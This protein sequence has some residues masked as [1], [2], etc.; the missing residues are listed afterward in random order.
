MPKKKKEIK[1]PIKEIQPAKPIKIEMKTMTMTMEDVARICVNINKEYCLALNDKSK[2][3]WNHLDE[4]KKRE[5]KKAINEHLIKNIDPESS[6]NLWMSEKT[7]QGWV[8]GVEINE[9]ERTH[10]CIVHWSELPKEQKA[11]D[12]L[13]CTI[14][15]ELKR[16]L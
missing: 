3:D 7:K 6:H 2:K 10:P 14:I 9:G 12:Y 4:E 15:N 11:K 8:Y 13:F 16:F 5:I 1:E